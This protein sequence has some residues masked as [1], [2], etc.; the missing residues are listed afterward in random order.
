MDPSYWAG[1]LGVSSPGVSGS[2]G[3]G[4]VGCNFIKKYIFLLFI[5]FHFVDGV[6]GKFAISLIL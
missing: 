4:G 5:I 3:G 1:E 6:G 2:G